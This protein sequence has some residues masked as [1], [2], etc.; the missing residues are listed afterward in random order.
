MIEIL[1]LVLG[2][3]LILVGANYLTDGSSKLAT[4][5]GI[6][7]FVVGLTIVA[8]GT[9]APELVVTVLSA[10][11]G[12]GDIAIGNIVGSNIFNI[13][14]ILG[15]TTLISPIEFT[16]SNILKDIPYGVVA[17]IILFVM[18][19]DTLFDGGTSNVISR[20]EGITMIV[21]FFMFMAYSVFS[22][23]APKD[24]SQ[25]DPKKRSSVLL[26]TVMIV[27]GL[28]ALVLGGNLFLDNAV[29]VAE[30][31]GISQKV[32]AIT[33]MA[34][35]TSLPEL[36]ACTVAA[37]KKK[38]EMAL[39]NVI[40]S[41]IS[42]IF[43]IL[44]T[45]ATITPLSLGDIKMEDIALVLIASVLLFVFAFTFKGKRINRVEGVIF[46]VIYVLYINYLLR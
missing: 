4:R 19:L 33:L 26:L 36:A 30:R 18:A 8:I 16:R 22:G 45:G 7:E 31:M 32:I 44:G 14:I 24:E 1:L 15:V 41:N 12:N 37:V 23:S 27:G 43:L 2:L 29:I 3:T 25:Q 20:S 42:N 40:G 34:G 11:G 9:S 6:S 28:F 46:I 5:F 10:T 13:L 17:S 21:M 35:G 38:G 39:G